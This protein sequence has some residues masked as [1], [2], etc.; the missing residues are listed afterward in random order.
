MYLSTTEEHITKASLKGTVENTEEIPC[1][2]ILKN[3]KSDN[4]EAIPYF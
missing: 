1:S 3:V 2:Q 4:E